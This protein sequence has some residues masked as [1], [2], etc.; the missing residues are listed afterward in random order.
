MEPLQH[1]TYTEHE[2]E[3]V[4]EMLRSVRHSQGAADKR[5][6]ELVSNDSEDGH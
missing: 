5:V 2:V 4:N 3:Q 1:D 6:L